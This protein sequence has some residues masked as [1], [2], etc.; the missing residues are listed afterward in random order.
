[1]KHIIDILNQKTMLTL[2]KEIIEKFEVTQNGKIRI[3]FYNGVIENYGSIYEAT[4][5]LN[6]RFKLELISKPVKVHNNEEFDEN[7]ISK[8][9]NNQKESVLKMLENLLSY[10]NESSST[11]A[12]NNMMKIKETIFFRKKDLSLFVPSDLLVQFD[13]IYQENF[14]NTKT[15]DRYADAIRKELQRATRL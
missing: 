6:T 13:K 14:V 7:D 2:Q 4:M 10:L 5:Y 1:M 12:P 9:Y 8:R 11:N 15:M 3:H